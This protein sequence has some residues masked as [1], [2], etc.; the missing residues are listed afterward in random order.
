MVV[1]PTKPE[2]SVLEQLS[3]PAPP[4]TDPD[5]IAEFGHCLARLRELVGS[6]SARVVIS[7][8]SGTIG[9]E[10]V[11]ASLLRPGVPVVV[12]ATGIW[13]ERWR[14][15]C[16]RQ[17][18]PVKTP[19]VATGQAPDLT[20][21]EEELADENC[22]AL[23]VTHVDSSTGVR[24]DLAALAAL[25]HKHGAL[26]L[27]DGISALGAET[28]EFDAWDVDC[29]LAGASKALGASPGL[30]LYSLS[31]RAVD[32]LNDRGWQPFSFA[33]D[34]APWLPVM[35]ATE[36]GEFAFFQSPASNLVMALSEAMRLAL[37]EGRQARV[38]RHETLR[39]LLH[40]GLAK[41][42][43]RPLV[44]A[45]AQRAN[46]VT[47]CLLPGGVDEQ[48]L[49]IAAAEQGVVLQAGTLPELAGRTFRIGHMGSVN[50]VAIGRTLTAIELALDSCR[51]GR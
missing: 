24:L 39:E 6:S 12:A 37:A 23:L 4:L 15:I 46:G 42:G 45:A 21:L 5:F 8:G 16:L 7:P 22:Q 3:L 11:V 38:S 25:A 18:V 36:R 26:L 49:L 47:V 31:E 14:K 48:E 50:A 1:G 20:R 2:R 41:L 29:Y 28:V 43:I 35:A 51:P 13:G 19:L 34:L 30:A 27:V 32:K 17:R 9:M 40:A 10:S 44:S 33:L